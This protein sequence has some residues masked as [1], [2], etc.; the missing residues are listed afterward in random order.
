[1]KLETFD[2]TVGG[3]SKKEFDMG[4]DLNPKLKFRE[5]KLR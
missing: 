1:L 4:V 5:A 3:G 2:I